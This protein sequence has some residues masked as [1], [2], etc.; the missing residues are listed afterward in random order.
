[1]FSPTFDIATLVSVPQPV[2]T[3]KREPDFFQELD[4]YIASKNS[5]VCKESIAT[6][7]VMKERLKAFEAYRRERLT[8]HS[9]DYNLYMEM[10][11]F[12][13]YHYILRRKKDTVYGLKTSTIGKT[14][15]QLRMFVKERVRRKIVPPIDMGDFKIVDEETDA[16]YLSYEEIG[17][18]YA[19]NLSADK[20]L[21]L[22]RDM[23]VLGC[24]TGLRF[25]DYSTLR[26]EDMRN[27]MLYKKN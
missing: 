5:S 8:F 16:I 24:L 13:T 10:M 3:K 1:M 7:R 25:S 11:E 14:I 22:Y 21:E 4:S 19:L 20:T 17:R 6:F 23:F 26:K 15:K 2:Q 27:G 18:I 12:F 9:L